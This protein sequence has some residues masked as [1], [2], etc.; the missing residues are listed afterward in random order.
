MAKQA[1]YKLKNISNLQIIDFPSDIT[2]CQSKFTEAAMG[3]LTAARQ[4]D[5]AQEQLVKILT[6]MVTHINGSPDKE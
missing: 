4:S 6:F 1:P 2:G 3:A 5:V